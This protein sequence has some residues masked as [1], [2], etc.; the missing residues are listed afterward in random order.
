MVQGAANPLTQQQIQTYMNPYTQN[1]VDATQAQFNNQNAQA[2]Q[3]MTGNSIAQGSLGGNRTAVGQAELAG[4]QNMA[5]APVI[6]GLYNQGYQGAL[7][8]AA[9]QFQQN[10]MAAA[11]QL[12]SLGVAGQNAGLQGAA[13]QFG[14][15]Q[16]QQATQQA[17]DAYNIGQFQQ[18]QAFPYQQTQ[19][20]AGLGTGVGSQMGGTSNGQT[21]ALAPD[22]TAQWAGLG[23]AGAG[24]LGQLGAFAP[25]LA[26]SDERAKENIHS[27]GKTHDGQNIY[28]F[29]YKGDPQTHVGLI[30]QEVEKKHPEAVHNIAGLKHVDYDAATEDSIKRAN[31]GVVGFAGGGIAG[32]PWADAPSYIPQV[33]GIAHGSGAS[34]HYGSAPAAYNPGSSDLSKQA[35]QI[36]DLAKQLTKGS[37]GPSGD[38]GSAVAGDIGPSSYGG[39]NGPTPLVQSAGVSNY[40]MGSPLY[41]RGGVV[42]G[43]ADGGDVDIGERIARSMHN[44]RDQGQRALY[45]TTRNGIW[46]S[47]TTPADGNPKALW[48][49]L[50]TRRALQGFDAQRIEDKVRGFAD[51]G[52]PG[53]DD[54]VGDDNRALGLD[55]LRK[56]MGVKAPDSIPGGEPAPKG[57]VTPDE[58][59]RMPDNNVGSETW[60]AS[61]NNPAEVTDASNGPVAPSRG[62]VPP[63]KAMAFSGQSDDNTS[64]V[65]S[66]V[67]LGY[68]KGKR[69]VSAGVA[70]PPSDSAVSPTEKYGVE[71]G[72]DGKLWPSLVSAGFGMMA[73]RSPFLGNAI[74]EGG[75]AGISS[76]NAQVNKQLEARRHAEQL[77]MEREKLDLSKNK[78][79]L[80]AAGSALIKGPNGTMIVNPAYIKQ[81]QAEA[82]VKTPITDYQQSQIDRQRR[83]EALKLKTPVKVMDTRSGTPIMAMPKLNPETNDVD[84]YPIM[85]D[86]KIADKPLAPGS[87]I[88]PDSV[89][90]ATSPTPTAQSASAI[91]AA[92]VPPT[93]TAS[94]APPPP[95]P[96]HE[97]DSSAPAGSDASRNTSFLAQIKKE[98]PR[99]GPGYAKLIESAANYEMDPSKIVSMK[100]DKRQ[101]FIED[102]MNFDPSYR[103]NE[104]TLRYKAQTAFLPGTKNGDTITAFNTAM[105]HLDVLKQLYKALSN[106]DSQLINKMKNTWHQM[107]G[108]PA[109][110]DVQA[111]ASIIG[112]EVV[113]ATVGAQNALGDREEV[114]QSIS[115]DL[116]QRQA[117]SVID[118]YQSL[119]AGQLNARKLAYEQSTGLK[120]FEEKFLSPRSRQVLGTIHE[121]A[122]ETPALST[123]DKQALEWANANPKD[124]RAAAIKKKLGQ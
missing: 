3:K 119:M 89:P 43:Y 87:S 58:P 91:P 78:Q 50:N 121:G 12:G 86:G 111:L 95:P 31:G 29:N 22:Q 123:Q 66:E 17:Q 99:G 92:T 51:G 107:T 64:E 42:P 100:T 77:Q 75:Q 114:R 93:E 120:N 110:N 8:T 9:Q 36:G 57:I 70:P 30:A 56:G 74:G 108:D 21:T 37:T 106:G 85:P 69:G 7:Q 40:N 79:E 105:S 60:R 103:P 104:A 45:N 109:P 35:S 32:T 62:V 115:R 65:P 49:D 90:A 24:M 112:G 44:G 88:Y 54:P 19:W 41:A 26:L 97:A 18:Q 20:L 1:V 38:P 84:L 102:V 80:E 82:N 14:V 28:R 33:A 39:P 72:P 117:D 113:K 122:V 96:P 34:A 2:S 27:V 81:K 53:L 73:S 116:S 98:D 118:K 55:L 10:P 94:T 46:S 67:A 68:S 11:N 23:M 4:Q 101:R 16:Q 63:A 76:Y 15:G 48:Q 124:P 83:E 52:S 13:A 61:Y 6:A 5:Q 25:L 47:E 71:W 59:I